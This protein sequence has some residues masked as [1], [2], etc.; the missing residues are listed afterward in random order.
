MDISLF[1][2]YLQELQNCQIVMPALEIVKGLLSRKFESVQD[3][4]TCPF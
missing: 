1:E 2:Q 4:L 3:I